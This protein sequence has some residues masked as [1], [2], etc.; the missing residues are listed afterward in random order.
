[1][2]HVRYHDEMGV[3]KGGMDGHIIR[4]YRCKDNMGSAVGLSGVIQ[5][6]INHKTYTLVFPALLFMSNRIDFLTVIYFLA[7]IKV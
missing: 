5:I 7:G 3:D 1:M 6:Q 2:P 4:Q